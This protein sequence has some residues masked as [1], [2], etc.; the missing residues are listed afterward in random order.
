M[1][2]SKVQFVASSARSVKNATLYCPSKFNKHVEC[3][4]GFT[5]YGSPIEL[6]TLCKKG[7]PI[8]E[9]LRLETVNILN[10]PYL[11]NA[12]NEWTFGTKWSGPDYSFWKFTYSSPC[13]KEV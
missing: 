8:S 12:I 6:L 3:I 13:R 4:L 5:Q 1:F 2:Q 11:G 10:Y 9:I 7:Q